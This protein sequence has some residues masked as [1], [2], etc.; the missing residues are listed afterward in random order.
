MPGEQRVQPILD[1]R[2]SFAGA[3]SYERIGGVPQVFEHVDDVEYDPDLDPDA[4]CRTLDPTQLSPSSRRAD[5]H[6]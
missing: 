6:P 2:F 5:S 1:P 3:R 4:L